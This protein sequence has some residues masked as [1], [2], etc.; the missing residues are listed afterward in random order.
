[1]CYLC[2]QDIAEPEYDEKGRHVIEGL[3]WWDG[4]GVDASTLHGQMRKLAEQFPNETRACHYSIPDTRNETYKP[5]CIVGQ[6]VYD[7]TGKVVNNQEYGGTVERVNWI[8]ALG[9]DAPGG[10]GSYVD[11]EELPQASDLYDSKLDDMKWVRAVQKKQDSGWTW[12][13]AVMWADW[14]ET[15][16]GGFQAIDF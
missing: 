1:M 16:D 6:G 13:Q 10:E 3:T 4:K 14:R 8:R 11:L 2:D 9:L 7:L 15:E 5:C 12:S